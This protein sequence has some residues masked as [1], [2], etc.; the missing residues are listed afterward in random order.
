MATQF[1]IVNE[2]TAPEY[3]IT[4]TRDGTAIDL[5]SAVSV[6]LIIKNKSTGTITQTG[7]SASLTSPTAGVITYTADAT[8]FPSAGTYVGD[9]KIT[10]STGVE[11]LYNQVKWKVRAKIA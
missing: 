6:T 5:S 11:I 9:V 3:Q 1:K 2:N 7:K 10:W 8:D 4:C